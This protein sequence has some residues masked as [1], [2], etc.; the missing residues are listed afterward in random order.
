MARS[1]HPFLQSCSGAI[2]KTIVVKNYAGKI[3]LSKY[4]DMSKVKRSKL[5]RA[6]SLLFGAAVAYAKR[7]C[8]DPSQVRTSYRGFC[9]IY[10]IHCD[11]EITVI[12]LK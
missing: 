8:N 10:G 2:G 4:P 9:P 3:V 5:Q 6:N 11:K 1:S 12:L 7:I